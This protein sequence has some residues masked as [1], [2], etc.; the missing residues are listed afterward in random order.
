MKWN[1]KEDRRFM[2]WL[3][4]LALTVIDGIFTYIFVSNF[5]VD[6][7]ANPVMRW[8]LTTFG[9]KGFAMYKIGATFLLLLVH[10]KVSEWVYYI[11]IGGYTIACVLGAMIALPLI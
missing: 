11:L 5:G 1:D 7:E 3:V 4:V 8:V 2:L 10:D 6:L 9:W